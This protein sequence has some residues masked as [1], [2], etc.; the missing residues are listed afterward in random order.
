MPNLSDSLVAGLEVY[1]ERSVSSLQLHPDPQVKRTWAGRAI[2][3]DN[4]QQ[5]DF[6]VVGGNFRVCL[7]EASPIE[8]ADAIE[9]TEFSSWPPPVGKV[10]FF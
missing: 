5:V 2:M 10:R 3:K 9:E 8:I 1:T 7:M 4:G 6:I